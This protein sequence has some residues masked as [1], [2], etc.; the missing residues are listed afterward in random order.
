MPKRL[1]AFN[2][3][4]LWEL[5]EEETRIVLDVLSA[6]AYD[7]E[8]VAKVSAAFSDAYVSRKAPTELSKPTKGQD[9]V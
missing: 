6:V 3:T 4:E 5:T 8:K 1:K 7:D 9:S 2:G